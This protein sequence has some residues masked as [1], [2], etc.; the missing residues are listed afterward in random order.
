MKKII[1]ITAPSGSGKSSISNYLLSKYSDKIAF[2]ISAATR[3]PRGNERDGVE[4]YFI[5]EDDFKKKIAEHQ[6]IEWEMVYQRNY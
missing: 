5:S 4:Y 6:F 3:S 2:S 1:V